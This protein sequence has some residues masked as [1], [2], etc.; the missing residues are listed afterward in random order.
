[1][2]KFTFTKEHR[3]FMKKSGA[4][5]LLMIIGLTFIFIGNANPEISGTPPSETGDTLINDVTVW[6]DEPIVLNGNLTITSSLTLNNVTLIMNCSFDGEYHIYVDG[7]ELYINNSNIASANPDYHYRFS[8]NKKSKFVMENT[9][10]SYCGY[11]QNELGL[12]VY[13]DNAWIKNCTIEKNYCGV[14]LYHEENVV[15][16]IENS[17]I[18]NNTYGIIVYGKKIA[19]YITNN[20]I[21]LNDYGIKCEVQGEELYNPP[22]IANNVI[23]LNSY[24]IKC[25]G[26]FSTITGNKISYNNIGIYCNKSHAKIENNNLSFNQK[27]IEYVQMYPQN[28]VVVISGNNIEN[29]GY[30]I[31]CSENPIVSICG[32]SI[33]NSTVSGIEIYNCGGIVEENNLTKNKIGIKCTDSSLTI[34]GN[35]I[36]NSANDG[37]Y[38]YSSYIPKNVKLI[39]EGN[40][41]N[42][43]ANAG[44]YCY[45]SLYV[46][47]EIEGNNVKNSVGPGIYCYDS[48]SYISKNNLS[49]N[50]WGIRLLG[51]SAM[52]SNIFESNRDG[53]VWQEWT[54]GVAVKN[55]TGEDVPN[56][57]VRAQDCFGNEVHI[58]TADE[59]GYVSMNLTEYKTFSNED[60]MD[61]NPYNITAYKENVGLSSTAVTI[62]RD[63]KIYPVLKIPELAARK[64]SFS[65]NLSEDQIINVNVNITNDGSLSASDV[66][67]E[68]F[69]DDTSVGNQTTTIPFGEYRNVFVPWHALSGSY[70]FTVKVD[71]MNK[72]DEKNESDNN[73]SRIIYI[74]AKPIANFSINVQEVY[75][76]ENIIFNA[77]SSN[78]SD[79]SVT[80]YY[81]D[82]GD[83][84]N[85]GWT[86]NPV[87]SYNY[88]HSGNYTPKLKVRDNFTQNGF[89]AESNWKNGKTITILNRAPVA[90]FTANP[91]KG[92]ANEPVVFDASNSYDDEENYGDTEHKIVKYFWDFGDGANA[93]GKIVS[94]AYVENGTYNVT[95]TVWDKEGAA[96]T[97]WMIITIEIRTKPLPTWLE[98]HYR[99][100]FLAVAVICCFG[101]V[102]FSSRWYMQAKRREKEVG[103]WVEK[104][105]AEKEKKMKKLEQKVKEWGEKQQTKKIKKEEKLEEWAKRKEEKKKAMEEKIEEWSRKKVA[106]KKAKEK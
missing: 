17:T 104:K 2:E 84:K 30:G 99:Q 31:F 102:F 12:S 80:E 83:G 4:L 21:M 67:V 10:L 6:K 63:L 57:N 97:T 76:Y 95:L 52:L 15:P 20:T 19:P 78:D 103:L 36:N 11:G 75:T 9:T 39:I 44:I 5:C 69:C 34:T 62:T 94:H 43:S 1:M 68:F 46:S 45:N 105:G 101:A 33:K 66:F 92:Y 42:N 91:I 77:S 55:E 47:L 64:I 71:P 87:I 35:N 40:N 53:R 38:C 100:V 58:L 26:D 3:P 29:S 65:G 85:S 50:I 24:G 14:Y 86:P 72:I 70:T 37:I 61:Y 90:N 27:G 25:R 73:M 18:K 23:I 88:T 79:G 82:F 32:N 56:A 59:N 89:T 54:V 60:R 51:E 7:G 106:E 41:V 93:T 8:V 16:K 49:N 48:P 22:Y 96:N 74:N 13:T 98:L 28:R 81:F